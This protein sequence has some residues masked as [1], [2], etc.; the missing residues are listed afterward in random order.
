MCKDG[1]AV[2]L[3]TIRT[4]AHTISQRL[5]I[6][7]KDFGASSGW[8]THYMRRNGLSL[9]RRM[10]LCLRLPFAYEDKVIDF[11]KFITT[12]RKKN[13]FLLSQIGNADQT[14]L[15]FDMPRSTTVNMWC[16]EAGMHHDARSD[17]RR[18]EAAAVCYSKTENYSGRE[19]FPVG[20][21]SVLK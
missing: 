20:S 18:L 1:C 7:T 3:D 13:A 6:A 21:T 16:G 9:R 8:T 2:S 10:S 5:G 15:T 19:T 4:Q 12:I 11:H 14:P 17:S